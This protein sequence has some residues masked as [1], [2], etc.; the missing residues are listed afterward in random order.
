MTKTDDSFHTLSVRK[1]DIFMIAVLVQKCRHVQL[2]CVPVK[3]IP[4]RRRLLDILA[5]I[6]EHINFGQRSNRMEV[7]SISF[8]TKTN[9]ILALSSISCEFLCRFTFFN[10][11][12]L[13]P[14]EWCWPVTRYPRQ[15][16]LQAHLVI[17]SAASG[18]LSDSTILSH[19]LSE[20]E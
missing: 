7:F 13:Q 18:W 3:N 14:G 2:F 19:S 9:N 12:H 16:S 11:R 20:E 17:Y 10:I 4:G 1:R 6:G 8:Q 15:R 5:A